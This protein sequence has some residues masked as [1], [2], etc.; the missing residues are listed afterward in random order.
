MTLRHAIAVAVAVGAMC[1]S[2]VQPLWIRTTGTEVA[3][4]LEPVDPLSLFR[5]NYVDLTYDISVELPGTTVGN[6]RVTSDLDYND[7]V[8]VVF[9]DARPANAVRSSIERP[10]LGPGETCVR[11][12]VR[13]RDRI[14]FPALEQYFVTPDEGRRLELDLDSMV[15]VVKATGSCRSILVRLEPA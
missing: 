14:E 10:T 7:L 9:D 12:T 8:Y 4:A 6:D 13:G 2:L 15:G 11:G 1:L 3:L 5:G